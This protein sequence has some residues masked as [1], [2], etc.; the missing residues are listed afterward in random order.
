MRPVT[1]FAIG[2]VF[3]TVSWPAAPAPLIVASLGGLTLLL[4]AALSRCRLPLLPAGVCAGWAL[5]AGVEAGPALDGDWRIRGRVVTA[6]LGQ[7]ADVEAASAAPR[8]AEARSARGRIRVDFGGDP[9]APGTVVLVEGA[10]SPPRLGRLPGEPDPAWDFARAGIRTTL[11]ARDVVRVGPDPPPVGVEGAQHSGLLRALAGG[12][13]T[14][15]PDEVA[16]LL[17]RTG[18][19]HLVSI[20][21][22]HIGLSAVCAWG[23][24]WLL[25]RPAAVWWRRGRL[26]WLCAAVATLAAVAWA[27]RA[28]W[29]V[30]ARR[31]VWMVAIAGICVAAGRRPDP[32]DLLGLGAIGTLYAEPAAVGSVSFH[33]SFGALAGTL[34]VV[35]RVVR[36]VP[37]DAPWFAAWVVGALATSVGATAGTL[38]VIAWHFQSV[39]WLSPAANLWA[40]PVIGSLATPAVMAAQVLPAPVDGWALAFAD[41]TIGIGLEGLRWLDVEPWSPAVGALGALLLVGAVFLRRSL[42]AAALVGAVA[43]LLRPGPRGEL[44]VTFLAIGQGDATLV[45]WPGGRTALIDGGPPGQGL[46]L[47]LRRMGIRRLDEVVL[48]HAHPDHYG[49]LIPVLAELSVGRL[50]A[51]SVPR[52]MDVSRTRVR[53]DAV[54][55]IVLLGPPADFVAEE[56]DLSLV[57][58]IRFGRRRFL[59]PGDAEA[60]GEASLVVD[61]AMSG[62]DLR[63]DVLKVGHHGSR[64]STTSAFLAAVAPEIAVIPC[65]EQNRYGHPHPEVLARLGGVRVYRTDE[66]GNVTIRTDGDS[67]VVER[68]GVPQRWRL[69]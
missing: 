48:S 4:L 68:E 39:S 53:R 35:P 20:S 7:T 21:G 36:F 64:T 57:T 45:R 42:P 63:A 59:F 61:A 24:A 17:R 25:T 50:R 30:P 34:F 2:V 69:R 19:W 46:L 23:A 52:E 27:A 31:S 49:G 8:G 13:R 16:T 32:W 56:N 43:L 58:A 26:R 11:R 67:L 33:L 12:S 55:P 15:I 44:Q 37:P 51:A 1:A 18:T 6:A 54:S 5:V 40:V 38:P 28:G 66:D 22:L 60:L 47:T 29:P 65:G 9:P 14:G 41:E 62:L 10:A 3:G